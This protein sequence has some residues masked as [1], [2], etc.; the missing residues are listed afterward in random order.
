MKGF[1]LRHQ[2]SFFAGRLLAFASLRHDAVTYNF[3][4]GN[5]YNR[6]GGALSTAGSVSH[7]TD[8]AWSPN[9]GLNLK[10]TSN[11]SFY[12][13]HSQSFSPAGQV[14]KLGDPHLENETSVG[15]DYGI[16]ASYLR[17]TLVFTLGGF[18]ID[19]NGVK[20]TQRDPVTGLNET[21]AAGKQL[22]K[23]VEFEGSWR[24][25]QGNTLTASYGYV[26]ARVVYNGNATTDV[27]QMPAGVPIDQGSLAWKY[28]FGRG[29]LKGLAWNTGLTY[30]GVAYPNSTAALTMR[31]GM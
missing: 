13:S 15:W 26:N 17:D 29:A 7:Y 2:A 19:R 14:A 21:I 8:T 1:L 25:S 12:A 30:S 23:G 4:F 5:Q 27:G 28:S 9:M 18:Y 22:T 3:L 6:A 31:A 20:T 16:K 10:A 11:I 24:I